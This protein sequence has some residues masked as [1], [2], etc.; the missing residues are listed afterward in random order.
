MFVLKDAFPVEIILHL[1]LLQILF[2]L[3]SSQLTFINKNWSV[4]AF[5]FDPVTLDTS[6]KAFNFFLLIFKSFLLFFGIL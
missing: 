2:H 1:Y 4:T 6:Y 5:W 3:V